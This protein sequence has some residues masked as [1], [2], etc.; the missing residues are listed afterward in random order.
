MGY[1]NIP[2]PPVPQFELMPLSPEEKK[3]QELRRLFNKK[4][5]TLI[6]FREAMDKLPPEEKPSY[7]FTTEKRI[8]R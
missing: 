1:C 3:R 4:K 6:E 7:I 8:T 5:I 2:V